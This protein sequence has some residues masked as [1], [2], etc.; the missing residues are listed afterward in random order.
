MN[1]RARGFCVHISVFHR[2][3]GTF[4]S[5]PAI[6]LFAY[7]ILPFLIGREN[8]SSR[9][10]GRAR[11]GHQISQ[12][13]AKCVR[14]IPCNHFASPLGH[15]AAHI[16]RANGSAT[17]MPLAI[18]YVSDQRHCQR[19]SHNVSSFSAL[20][21][22]IANGENGEGRPRLCVVINADP[23]YFAHATHSTALLQFWT[24][25]SRL[26]NWFI[27]H[28]HYTDFCKVCWNTL[29]NTNKYVVKY[30]K[31]MKN[32]FPMKNRSTH[33]LLPIRLVWICE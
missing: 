29:V 31:A 18:I 1:A 15:K 8:P 27:L 20:R 26:V 33:L 9:L 11:R 28:S 21:W 2:Q 16:R 3:V 23:I 6:Y 5:L 10:S 32:G 14:L 4:P 13:N 30:I 24:W 19:R 12:S 17:R 22:K 25:L 7:F